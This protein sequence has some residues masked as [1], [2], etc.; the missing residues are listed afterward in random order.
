MAVCLQMIH[1]DPPVRSPTRR[2]GDLLALHGL[3]FL[4]GSRGGLDWSCRPGHRRR[5]RHGTRPRAGGNT[6]SACPGLM[7][8][9]K[10]LSRSASDRRR[11]WRDWPTGRMWMSSGPSEIALAGSLAG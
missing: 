9:E 11:T 10:S 5:Y 1:E 3:T 6:R 7:R 8:L 2:V 4:Q